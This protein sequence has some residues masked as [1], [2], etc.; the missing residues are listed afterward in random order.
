MKRNLVWAFTGE[1]P[2]R[3]PRTA[4]AIL[5]LLLIA[6][7]T[8]FAFRMADARDSLSAHRDNA[9]EW[10]RMNPEPPEALSEEEW[11]AINDLMKVKY[12]RDLLISHVVLNVVVIP[13]ILWFRRRGS[14]VGRAEETGPEAGGTPPAPGPA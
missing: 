6:A 7:W 2:E 5:P 10:F 12:R 3:T 1:R 11:D 14:G 13:L 4:D 8:T 9:Q